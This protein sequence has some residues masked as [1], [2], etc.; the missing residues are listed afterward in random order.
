MRTLCLEIILLE[1]AIQYGHRGGFSEVRI[2]HGR[3]TREVFPPK[4]KTFEDFIRKWN[5]KKIIVAVMWLIN[6]NR[7]IEE[8][9]LRFISLYFFRNFV[10]QSIGEI[11]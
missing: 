4:S 3:E 2:P 7:I 1:S 11:S 8:N 5:I 6:L 10:Q 9:T